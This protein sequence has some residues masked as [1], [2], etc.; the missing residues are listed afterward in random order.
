[1]NKIDKTIKAIVAAVAVGMGVSAC[2]LDLL[3][4]NEVVLENYWTN[5]ADVESVVTSCYAAMQDDGYVS[6]MIV[7]G[8]TR[9]DNVEETTQSPEALK[10]LM[11]GTIKSTSSYCDWSAFYTVINRCNT[12][13]HY[14]PDVAEKDPNYTN[15]ELAI[16]IAECKALRAISYLTLIKT[17]KDVPFT[18]SPS[19]DD[20][21]NYQ[22]P[23]TSFETILDALIKDIE[24]SKNDAPKQYTS[25]MD[26]TGRITR[27]AMYSI[28]ADLYL[29]K[30]SDANLDKAEQNANYEKCIEC[31][32]WVL[33]FKQQQFLEN[34]RQAVGVNLLSAVDDKVYTDYGYPLLAEESTGGSMQTGPLA[35]N[36]I[37]GDGN[38]YEA[39]FEL[40]YEKTT[41]DQE[42]KNTSVSSMYGSTDERTGNVSRNLYA[43]AEM[44]SVL[45]ASSTYDDK[46]LFS[47]PSDYRALA[48][49]R[50]TEG[51]S[52]QINK[53][54]VY[55]NMAG[56]TESD[57]YGKV[58]QKFE[59]MRVEQDP[60]STNSQYEGW[61]FYRMSEIMLI[62]A[63]AEI[64]LAGNLTEMALAE[65]ENAE[66][67]NEEGNDEGEGEGDASAP[68]RK[69]AAAIDGASLFGNAEALYDDAFNLIVAVY[70]RSNPYA[71]RKSTKMLPQRNNYTD[72]SSFETLLYN[73]RRREFLFE[74]KRYYDLVRVSRREGNMDFFR[75]ALSSRYESAAVKVKLGIP[76]FMYMPI[77]KDQL[78]VNPRLKQNQAYYDEEE[79]VK[80]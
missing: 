63:E 14:A 75:A 9:S 68:R 4:L 33:K 12:V 69:A 62:R 27:A 6:Q 71:L 45:P 48:P 17:F 61:I 16:N 35:T 72:K 18:L 29:W 43:S 65:E 50:Y 54:V 31:C 51:G 47:V 66:E 55:S 64:E 67:G 40:T 53:Y 70:A 8:E 28:L 60:R 15:S 37:F 77:S 36:M 3:P 13:I 22:I 58:G 76:D 39:I 1:M 23:A 7:W 34:N 19:I 41:S 30:A 5:K 25:Y 42:K 79:T 73:E 57:N 52:F 26:N 32:D 49:F 38:S 10:N 11:K 74:A 56:Y 24:E 2:S 21:L 78:K 20:N 59:A 80:N 44:M 46:N